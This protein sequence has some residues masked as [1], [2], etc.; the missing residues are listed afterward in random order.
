[1]LVNN[2]S[3]SRTGGYI[4]PRAHIL[5]R[6]AQYETYLASRSALV[7]VP[8]PIPSVPT[9]SPRPLSGTP[10]RPSPP[11]LPSCWNPQPPLH[12]PVRPSSCTAMS[13]KPV[14]AVWAKPSAHSDPQ[15]SSRRSSLSPRPSQDPISQAKLEVLSRVLLI[16][17]LASFQFVSIL[18]FLRY[19]LVF[20]ASWSLSGSLF[21]GL[22]F[23]SV[24]VFLAV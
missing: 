5:V 8:H 7:H 9:P 10:P 15:P 12:P 21:W 16:L 4:P 19:L 2:P 17:C 23:P 1:M 6:V 20:V 11:P 13:G 24:H 18:G 22:R 14:G 3:S